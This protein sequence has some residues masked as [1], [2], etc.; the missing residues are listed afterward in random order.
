MS[1]QFNDTSNY[2]GLVQLYEKELGLVRGSISGDTNKLKHF[3]ADANIAFDEFVEM[4]IKYSGTW[5]FDDSNQSDYPIITTNLVASQRD[6]SFTTDETGNLILDIMRVF[7]RNSTSDPYYE[8]YPVDSQTDQE[9]KVAGLVDGLDTTGKAS[10]Y[11]K[12]ANG[13]FLDPIPDASVTNGLKVYINREP[14]YFVHTDTTKKPGVPGLF[15]EWFYKKPALEEAK[16]NLP[17]KAP[18][19]D[20][21]VRELRQRIE[22]Y[23]SK[24]ERD[25]RHVMTP[26]PPRGVRHKII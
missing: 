20:L 4:A 14:S 17:A 21:D 15:H 3:T 18:R 8:I 22:D 16:R 24:R 19:L 6:Y 11:D 12:T 7:V 10:K 2:K 23:F 25:V 13:I 9:Y 26:A 5:Q 1:I